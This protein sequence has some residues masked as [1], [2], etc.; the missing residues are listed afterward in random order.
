[1]YTFIIYEWCKIRK[2]VSIDTVSDFRYN[3]TPS[4]QGL[5]H[6]PNNI[7]SWYEP[8]KDRTAIEVFGLTLFL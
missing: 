1:M 2:Q 7:D 4:T 8:G 3:E 5:Y 6:L